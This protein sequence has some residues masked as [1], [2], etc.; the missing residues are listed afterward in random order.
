SI[1][2]RASRSSCTPET[3][4][5]FFCPT[6]TSAPRSPRPAAERRAS[7]SAWATTS[8]SEWPSQPSTPS[9]SRPASQ[10]GLPASIWWASVEIPTRGMIGSLTGYL[11]DGGF[12]LVRDGAGEGHVD[13]G[14]HLEGHGVALH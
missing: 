8:P 14:G 11:E 7:T 6:P 10:Q 13:G 9:K 4:S 2:A 12:G 3:P 5:Y 1:A